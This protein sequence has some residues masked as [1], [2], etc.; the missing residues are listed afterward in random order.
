MLKA[1][2]SAGHRLEVLLVRLLFCLFADDTGI[3]SPEGAFEDLVETS[4]PDGSDLGA[5]LSRLFGVLNTKPEH[6]QKSL[7]ER[8]NAF[9][10]VNGGL[11]AD[12]QDISEFSSAMRATLLVCCGIAWG[13]ISPAIFGAMFQKITSLESGDRRR[14]M[15]AYY[16]SEA[17]I[18]KVIRPLFLDELD[19]EFE[20]VK[21]NK[22]WLFEFQKKLRR[23]AFLDPA[24]G[25]G[26]FLV[27]TY[28]ELRRLELRV[29][30]ASQAFGSVT[31]EVFEQTG[32]NVDQFY[33]IEIEDFPA[34]IV[35]VAIWL[36]DHQMNLEAGQFF[37]DWIKRIP[38]DKSAEIRHGNALRIEWAD[39][40]PPGRLGY[41]LG[42]PPFIGY[43]Y[44]TLAQK[45]DL[46]FVTKGIQGVG[47]LDYVGGWYLKAAQYVAGSQLGEA[48]RDRQQFLDVKFA[49]QSGVGP[50][51]VPAVK[52]RKTQQS[53]AIDDL[54]VSFEKQDAANR[55]KVR[56]AFVSTNSITQGEQVG[57]LWGEMLRMGMEID[58]AHRT[59]QW[60]NDA[61]G[62]AAV[63]CVIVGS[64][65]HS[66][67]ERQL[68]SYADVK[69]EAVAAHVEQI[70]P[71][72]VDAPIALIQ[73]RRVPICVVP[74]M[75]KGSQP[76]DGSNRLMSDDEKTDLLAKEPA[77]APWIR[78]FLG[79]EEVLHAI[80]R[81]GQAQAYESQGAKGA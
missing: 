50:I 2:G 31:R 3:F 48:S 8:F 81:A 28:R 6:R 7:D 21:R 39:F 18:L 16:T 74:R 23:L 30:Q 66:M 57:V 80:R 26:N 73:K 63:H 42:N 43:S 25:C 77:A 15:G 59:F 22:N 33:G 27:I 17:N 49:T 70:N 51:T 29:L 35:Q 56:C 44:Q 24:C 19:A 67:R 47:V 13:V 52:S 79:A 68:W 54:F 10:Y 38:L 60:S 9:P 32:V 78:P 55:L 62:K 76:T 5:T 75:T 61:P 65:A 1:D 4:K 71:Y 53:A 36:V 58:F 69:A 11:Y 20:E 64:G 72:L 12:K 14:Q 46:A 34:Q 41:I 37:G 45:E 40:C